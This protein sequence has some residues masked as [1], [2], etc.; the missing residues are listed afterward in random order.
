MELTELSLNALHEKLNYWLFVS[1]DWEDSPNHY[2]HKM[3]E[4]IKKV[5][6]S[7]GVKIDTYSFGEK[8]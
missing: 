1:K 8:G 2:A 5:I 7:H 6:R 3:V 4:D